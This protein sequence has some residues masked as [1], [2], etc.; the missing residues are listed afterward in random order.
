MTFYQWLVVLHV[1]GAFLFVLFHGASAAVVFRIRRETDV[2][3]IQ[4]LLDLSKSM[5]GAFYV[6]VLLML[7]TG[8]W[9]GIDGGWFSRGALWLWTAIGLL[10]VVAVAMYLLISRHFYGWREL[11]A[12]EPAPDIGTIRTRVATQ[13][14][15][16][17]A[18][19]GL[20]GLVIIVWLM[21]AK[22]F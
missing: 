5:L 8:I 4:A 15:L 19:I 6:G 21:E 20:A 3:R 7:V 11:L 22:P 16:V 12:T 1:I 13:Q 10:V 14:P 2:A 18:A 17:G 9:A